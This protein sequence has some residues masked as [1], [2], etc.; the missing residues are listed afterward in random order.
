MSDNV[1]FEIET[2]E[3][4]AIAPMVAYLLSDASV[5]VTGQIYTVVGPRISV[6]NQPAEVRTMFAPNGEEWTPAEIAKW[7]PTTIK[8]EEHPMLR[9]L[10]RREAQRVA[11]Q[12]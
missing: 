12:E 7:L 9:D 2:G 10:A 3:P 8:S 5:G 11:S 6:W 1:P 4:T